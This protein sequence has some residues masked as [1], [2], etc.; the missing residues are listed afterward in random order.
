MGDA[1]PGQ[2][3]HRLPSAPARSEEWPTGWPV[4]HSPKPRGPLAGQW[5][6]PQNRPAHRLASGPPPGPLAGQWATARPT[7]W[8]VGHS[9][10]P[11]GPLAGQWATPPSLKTARNENRRNRL[12]T[13][14]CPRKITRTH[15]SRAGVNMQ[16]LPLKLPSNTRSTINIHRLL[17]TH[18]IEITCARM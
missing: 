3:A 9:P 6:T 2:R 17:P 18:M 10:K 12:V 15:H 13:G 11:P 4:G 16:P 1:P 8:P 7:G 14:H 5:A